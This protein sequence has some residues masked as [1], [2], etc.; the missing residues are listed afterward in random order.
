MNGRVIRIILLME[1]TQCEF[2]D[3][4]NS[5]IQ[6]QRIFIASFSEKNRNNLLSS[7]GITTSHFSHFDIKETVR[8]KVVFS[9]YTYMFV[10][11]V[12]HLRSLILMVLLCHLI[13]PFLQIYYAFY[14]TFYQIVTVYLTCNPNAY[15]LQS[16]Y[17][18][19]LYFTIQ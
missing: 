7:V 8:K 17:S 11:S 10:H 14:Q 13:P 19:H 5:I 18:A 3:Q 1:S 15:Q 4:T 12:L 16:H 2:I 6:W 9:Y